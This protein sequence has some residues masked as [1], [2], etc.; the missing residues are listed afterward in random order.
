MSMVKES[1]TPK[2]KKLYFS[3]KVNQDQSLAHT[4]TIY[5]YIKISSSDNIIGLRLK[6]YR[7]MNCFNHLLAYCVCKLN[8]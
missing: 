6:C 3:L 4:L 1:A 8:E 5:I 2:L 7:G